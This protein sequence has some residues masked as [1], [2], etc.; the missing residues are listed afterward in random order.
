MYR[1]LSPKV[2]PKDKQEELQKLKHTIT[3][4]TPVLLPQG[5]LRKDN[6]RPK[7]EKEGPN[8]APTNLLTTSPLGNLNSSAGNL[9]TGKRAD[10]KNPLPKKGSVFDD[11]YEKKPKA[12]QQK[13]KK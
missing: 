7:K 5:L 2:S 12:T 3:G 4:A 8:P 9:V 10:P 13:D 6:Q 11:Y 1:H